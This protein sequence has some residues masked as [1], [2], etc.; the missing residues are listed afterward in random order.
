M[1]IIITLLLFFNMA[2]LYFCCVDCGEQVM[3]ARHIEVNHY[4]EYKV[5]F[6]LAVCETCHGCLCT[7]C[8]TQRFENDPMAD[9]VWR[10]G[11]TCPSGC[12]DQL[13]L[14]YYNFKHQGYL[15][16]ITP[17]MMNQLIQ[18]LYQN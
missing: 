6:N 13:M 5:R 11:R 14:A 2:N 12:E 10:P 17:E 18:H 1:N 3:R 9:Q 15:P 7:A 8:A 16:P 4:S